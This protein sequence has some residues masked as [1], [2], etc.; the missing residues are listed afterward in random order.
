MSTNPSTF[1]SGPNAPFIEEL[2]ARY[3]DHPESV[4]PSWRKFFSDLQDES[5]RSRSRATTA[6]ATATTTRP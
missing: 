1:L 5:E 4:D 3:L 6:P 2:Y